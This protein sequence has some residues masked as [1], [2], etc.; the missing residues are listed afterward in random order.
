MSSI[1][2]SK[3][4]RAI[5]FTGQKGL[6]GRLL[7]PLLAP[8]RTI[9]TLT[10][11]AIT[12]LSVVSG[13]SLAAA[14]PDKYQEDW[15]QIEVVIFTHESGLTSNTEQWHDRIN[16][17]YPEN[18]LVLKQPQAATVLQSNPKQPDSANTLDDTSLDSIPP[19]D[20]ELK[21]PENAK[22]SSEEGASFT[23]TAQATLAYEDRQLQEPDPSSLEPID[24]EKL[25]QPLKPP[26]DLRVAPFMLLPQRY[27]ELNGI[28]KRIDRAMDMRLL[29]HFAW[30]QPV[31]ANP[32]QGQPVL[33]Q[34][35]K[36]FGLSFEVEG[37]M[38][39][40]KNRY[41]HIDTDFFYS[42]FKQALINN[43]ISWEIF[44]ENQSETDS[45]D[46]LT[47]ESD[48]A[49]PFNL[50]GQTQ[51][52]FQREITAAYKTVK[53][54]SENEI[55]Y[56]DHPLFGFLIKVSP[57]QLPDPVLEMPDF[58][59]DALPPRKAMPRVSE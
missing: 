56:L 37:L 31:T 39:L 54:I 25:T 19:T 33:I 36:Q 1:N 35:G 20:E 22:P 51:D 28:S 17:N 3:I 2:Q 4:L 7:Q 18:L 5:K 38:T 58:N 50:L 43:E 13:L 53:R 44:S 27:F 21:S 52:N 30:R 34:A 11:L 29:S 57:Y 48:Y 26:T 24:L 32:S 16:L 41:L 49:K 10:L 42:T 23:P 47:V 55:H 40:L 59:L 45:F 14:L 8:Y 12:T 15:Y 46:T 6:T 9:T